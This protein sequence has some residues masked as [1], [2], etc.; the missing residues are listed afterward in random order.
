LQNYILGLL[1][2]FPEDQEKA[3]EEWN[4][5]Q[6]KQKIAIDKIEEDFTLPTWAAV[7]L[8]LPVGIPYG[9]RTLYKWSQQKQKSG[10]IIQSLIKEC[11]YEFDQIQQSLIRLKDIEKLIEKQE[12]IDQALNSVAISNR[13]ADDYIQSIKDIVQAVRNAYGPDDWDKR[14]EQ[15]QKDLPFY[16]FDSSCK[17]FGNLT[18]DIKKIS[19]NEGNSQ[20]RLLRVMKAAYFIKKK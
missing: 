12:Q 7:L 4:S 20:N 14:I 15:L 13:S 8:C 10:E 2:N 11:C 1:G 19:I 3:N 5:I 16:W 6:Q 17:N 18:D 9:I